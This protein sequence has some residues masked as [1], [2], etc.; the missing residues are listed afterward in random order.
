MPMDLSIKIRNELYKR[1]MKH[2]ELA[3]ELGISGAYLSDILSG[4]RTGKKAQEHVKRI[5]IIL[6][7]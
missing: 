6:G 7:I 4:K 1:D 5:K 3:K 2:S